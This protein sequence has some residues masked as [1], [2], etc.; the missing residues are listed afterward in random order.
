LS[1]HNERGRIIINFLVKKQTAQL[2]SDGESGGK[3][4]TGAFVNIFIVN[5][6]LSMG[7][8]MMNTLIPKYAYQLGGGAAVVGMVAGIFAVTA[9]GV[10]PL[11]GPAIDYFRKNR[12]L[13]LSIAV[14]TLAYICYGFAQNITM[15]IIA[16]LIHG[17]GMGFMA[18]LSLAL[19]S[20]TLP[21]GKMASGLGL[22]SLGSAVATA[23]GPSLGLK[24]ADVIGYNPAFFICAGLMLTCFL[25]SLRLKSEVPVRTE[26]FRISL[27]QIIAPEVILPTLVLF[28]QML[29]YSGINSFLAIYGGL[30]GIDNIGLFFTMNAI[31]MIVI[32]PVS[33]RIADKYGLDKTVIP[34]FFVFIAALVMISFSK[35]LPMFLLSGAV[36]ALGFGISEPIMQTLNM[37]LVPKDRRGAAGNTNFMGIDIGFLIGPT[38]AGFVISTVQNATGNELLGFSVMYRLMSVPVIAAIVIFGLSRKKLMSRIKKQQTSL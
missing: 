27:R 35:T 11:A 34:G 14:V 20:N 23:I 22:F 24:L 5:F 21:S 15:V 3:I 31:C 2:S 32:R 38:L 7:Q 33:G 26:R 16:R 10:R 37:Q 1:W 30:R 17:I 25:L 19:V 28:F 12:L 4:W 9:L 29:A 13:S 18:P 36:T 6:V 8:Y